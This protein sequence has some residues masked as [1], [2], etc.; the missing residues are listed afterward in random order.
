MRL[1]ETC[2]VIFPHCVCYCIMGVKLIMNNENQSPPEFPRSVC[3]P[4]VRN[5]SIVLSSLLKYV[6]WRKSIIVVQNTTVDASRKL[7]KTF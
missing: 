2:W 1:Y 6:L 7:A 4:W 5:D 3:F